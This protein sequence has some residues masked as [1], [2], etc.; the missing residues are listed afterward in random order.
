MVNSVR[1]WDKLARKYAASKISDMA[2]YEKS[3]ERTRHYLRPD[4]RVIEY[5]CGT[6]STALRLAP[7]VAHIQAID[8]SAEMIAIAREK[9][10]AEGCKNASF[11]T[12]TP[13]QALQ[14]IQPDAGRYDAALAFNL[15][16]LVE[17]RPGVLAAIAQGLKPGGI[18]ISKT[19]CLTEINIFIRAIIPLAQMIGK[20]P[21]VSTFSAEQLEQELQAAGF[22]IV[23]RGRHGSKGNDPR[24]YLAAQKL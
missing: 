8:S 2:G 24:P 17:D 16:H 13:E 23:E 1:F 11:D 4:H 7:S 18:F 10:A 6:G 14:Q 20:A 5:G 12:A 19:P 3:L 22:E 9:A 21:Y 15:L